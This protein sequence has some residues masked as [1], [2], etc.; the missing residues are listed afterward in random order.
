M[1][2]I[3]IEDAEL[4]QSVYL[5]AEYVSSIHVEPKGT[6]CTNGVSKVE[7]TMIYM[8]DGFRMKTSEPV[9][10]VVKKVLDMFK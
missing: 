8:S 10:D 6:L 5:N 3:M 4:G 2:L 7:H 9:L 1:K